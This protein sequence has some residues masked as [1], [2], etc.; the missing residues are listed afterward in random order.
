[1]NYDRSLIE[2]S[3]DALFITDPA[4]KI[5]NMNEALATITGKTSEKITGTYFSDYFIEQ[6]KADEAYQEILSKGAVADFPLTILHKSG[7]L[8]DVLLSGSVYKDNNDNISGVIVA[9]RDITGQKRIENE[10]K[11]A[12]KNAELA[13]QKAEEAT[14]LKEAFLANMSHE[15]RTP[16]N[17]IIG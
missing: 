4:G 3:R 14:K 13:M 8:T 10:L 16:L 7:K 5:T 2:T 1:S 15:I 17:A 11:E 6:Q 12:K 9:A